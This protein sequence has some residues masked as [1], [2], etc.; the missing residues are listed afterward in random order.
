MA[1]FARR[2]FAFHFVADGLSHV[3]YYAKKQIFKA[4]LP[5]TAKRLVRAARFHLEQ[6]QLYR[7][8]SHNIAD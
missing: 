8:H 1:F 3:V 4:I 6:M 7:R 2:H 5:L